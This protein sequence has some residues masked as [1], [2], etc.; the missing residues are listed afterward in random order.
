MAH[1]YRSALLLTLLCAGLAGAV[2]AGP[3][4]PAN[5]EVPDLILLV[6]RGA[7]GS[8]DAHGAFTV[9]L[10]DFNNVPEENREVTL[11]FSHCPDIRLCADQGDPGVVTDCAAKSV[12]ATA[13]QDGRVT[14]RVLGF[15]VNSGASPGSIGPTL[16]VY[17]EGIFLETV[18]VSALDQNGDGVNPADLSLLLGDSFSGQAYARSDYDG[19]GVL[20]P[21][22]VSLW[23]AAFF[24]GGSAVSGGA[25]CP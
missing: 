23:L 15:A 19:N 7:G 10:R 12:R 6:G 14:F 1:I 2:A 5:C 16:E 25:A 9:V 20:D 21:N 4:D 22:D 13:G 24:A 18:R 3:P 8:A 17:V 11:D